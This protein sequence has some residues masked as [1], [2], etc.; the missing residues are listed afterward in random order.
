MK[1]LITGSAGFIGFHLANKLCQDTKYK[2]V[3]IDNINDY[4]STKIKNDRL[5]ILKKHRNFFFYKLNI[6][7]FIKLEKIFNKYKFDVVYNLAAQA[8]VRYSISNPEK[9]IDSNIVGFFNILEISRINKIK[10]LVIASSSSVYGD[11]KNF[12]LKEDANTEF[13]ISFYA[14]TKKSNEVMSHSY[15]YIYKMNITIVRFFTV[16]GP[17]GRPDMSLFKFVKNISNGKAIEV[18]NNGNHIRDFTYVGD[19]ANVLIK[20]LKRKSNLKVPYQVF[21][22]CS[23]NAVPLKKFIQLIETNLNKK[24]KIKNLGMQKGD[25]VK[26][27]GHN[28]KL[29][30]K[31]GRIKFTTIELGIKKFINW[32]K[33]YY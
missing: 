33:S 16:Y 29:Q 5:K 23:G 2:V 26:T 10:H 28:A 4:Y 13:P 12:P 30:N 6:N 9:Y 18:F 7:N 22:I 27:H 24:A 15:S 3:G 17:Y 14:A 19:V 11:N 21:N 1:I 31:I 25:I 20:L 32:Y 8:G